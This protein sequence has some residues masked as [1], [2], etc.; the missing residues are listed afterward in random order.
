M[1]ENM[2]LSDYFLCVG[3][4]PFTSQRCG[5]RA[6]LRLRSGQTA[7]SVD[8]IGALIATTDDVLWP[9]FSLAL[10]VPLR[11]LRYSTVC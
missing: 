1:Q 6:P 2:F 10:A 8:F 11:S 4:L 7:V 9:A 3:F 5:N